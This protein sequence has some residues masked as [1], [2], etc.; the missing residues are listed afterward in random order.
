MNFVELTLNPL[1]LTA[2]SN[3]V[4][5]E[6]CGAVSFFVGTTRNNFEGQQVVSL[7]YECYEGM[8]RKVMVQLCETIRAKWPDVKNCAIFHRLGC[9][10]VKEASVVIAISSPHRQTSLD[11]VAFGINEL[12]RNVPIWK[13]EVY[14]DNES[15]WKENKECEWSQ[16]AINNNN[17]A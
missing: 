14:A 4:A 11:A 10:P 15:T 1:D 8:A 13:K 6:T 2:I 9:V 7:E 17:K 3:Q 5:D 12:K 16:D